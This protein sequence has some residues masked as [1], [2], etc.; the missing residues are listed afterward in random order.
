MKILFE[1]Y[2][3]P[4]SIIEDLAMS[5]YFFRNE[6]NERAQ[7]P[8]VGYYYSQD[9]KD[10]VF[11]LPKVFLWAVSDPEFPK[12]STSQ[13]AFGRWDPCKI[14]HSRPD[15]NP[16][17]EDGYDQ[18][19]FGLST[20]L[21]QAIK[22]YN[23]RHPYSQI[24]E[25]A[26]IQ[27]VI[28][29]RGTSSETYLD[30]ILSLIRFQ[31]EHQ[32]L[33]TYIS[34]INSSGNNKIHWGKTVSKVQPIINEDE[35]FYATFKNKNKIINFDEELIVLFYSVLGWL[36]EKY[37]FPIKSSLNYF[38]FPS[39]QIDAMIDS[40][41]GTRLLRSIRKKYFTDE[42]V[43]LWKLLYA[44]FEKAESIANHNYHEEALLVHNFNMVFEDMI[45]T[46]ISDDNQASTDLKTNKDDKRIDHIFKDTSLV[47]SDLIYYIADSKYYK[48][49]TDIQGTSLYK[50]YT[51]ARNIIQYNIDIFNQQDRGEHLSQSKKK[52]IEGVRYRDPLT[53]GYNITPNF[54]I[55]GSIYPEDIKDGKADYSNPRLSPEKDPEDIRKDF[56]RFNTHFENR[57]FDRDTLV[58]KSYNINFLFVLSAFVLQKDNRAFRDKVKSTFR[59]QLIE[60]FNRE[61]S[62]F[63]L[64]PKSLTVEEFV[65][66]YFKD[67]IG[68]IYRSSE[69]ADTLWLALKQN[70]SEEVVLDLIR[71]DAIIE[72]TT[73]RNV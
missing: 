73:L 23:V 29:N 33:F 20:W 69:S 7:I 8:Y 64:T 62:F 17:K 55:R 18:V 53:E 6:E 46:L 44:F 27:N 32:Q 30:I 45:D 60:A 10:S 56:I 61:Y 13:L 5:P 68:K 22:R 3:Y 42:L 19:V 38:V 36:R 37:S 39:R 52:T 40:G 14:I 26:K 66:K 16:L 1:E 15:D 2:S 67:L 63:I 49:T 43:A 72:P 65:H 54:F 31:K 51:Y 47:D 34:I 50:Q 70:S 59:R 24:I 21:Y 9:L 57:L 12:H 41:R 48:E 25:N 4:I 71:A 58:L 11:I 35:P 28:S